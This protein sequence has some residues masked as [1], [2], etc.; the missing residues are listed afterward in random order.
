MR[1]NEYRVLGPPTLFF[2]DDAPLSDN[3]KAFLADFGLRKSALHTNA[4]GERVTVPTVDSARK[5]LVAGDFIAFGLNIGDQDTLASQLQSQELD[6][7]IRDC[8][9]A[10]RHCERYRLQS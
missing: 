1:S 6:A 10:R 8:R 2:N 4:F 5:V 9:S 3:I 7:A